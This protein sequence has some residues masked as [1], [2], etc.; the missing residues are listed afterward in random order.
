MNEELTKKYEG[1][2]IPK[3]PH[4]YS[5]IVS[6]FFTRTFKRA[7]VQEPLLVPITAGNING[8]HCF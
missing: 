4:W 7:K 2:D 1:K 5:I 3:P 6:Y 8:L